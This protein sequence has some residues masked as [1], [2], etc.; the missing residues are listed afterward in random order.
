ML[1][2][3]VGKALGPDVGLVVSVC[4][5]TVGLGL[6]T[7]G[8]ALGAL[9]GAALGTVGTALGIDGAALGLVG[10]ILKVGVGVGFQVK[11]VVVVVVVVVSLLSVVT[12]IV[13]LLV[14]LAVTI[15]AVGFGVASCPASFSL[16]CISLTDTRAIVFAYLPI[17]SLSVMCA[18]LCLE[19]VDW[20]T[21]PTTGIN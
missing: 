4:N 17:K 13:G 19:P 16:L 15:D 1:G 8:P 12:L 11:G 3:F 7:V 21:R 20:P 10:K 5:K 6:D 9:L 18:T 2:E 14:G